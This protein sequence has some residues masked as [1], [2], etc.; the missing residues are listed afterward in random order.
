M[1]EGKN[2]KWVRHITYGSHHQ[3][4]KV[5]TGNGS[6]QEKRYDV[7]NLCLELLENGRRTSFIPQW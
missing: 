7:E 6:M 1:V 2:S 5:E 4:I 3:L